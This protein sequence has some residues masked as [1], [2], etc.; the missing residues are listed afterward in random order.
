MVRELSSNFC[1]FWMDFGSVLGAFLG[2]F[3]SQSASKVRKDFEDALGGVKGG[4]VEA[5]GGP[6]RLWRLKQ[7]T[8]RGG[9]AA[10]RRNARS[11]FL[12]R[13]RQEFDGSFEVPPGGSTAAPL[14]F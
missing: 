13:I 12:F 8:G 1:R 10:A 4:L 14:S 11:P 7:L 6:W 9:Q 5:F 3:G 2:H